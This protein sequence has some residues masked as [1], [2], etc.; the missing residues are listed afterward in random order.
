MSFLEY[1]T[2][3][4]RLSVRFYFTIFIPSLLS[5]DDDDDDDDDDGYFCGVSASL[6]ITRLTIA[7]YINKPSIVIFLRRCCFS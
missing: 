2:I 7:M 4:L 1:S 5:F 3:F 6:S